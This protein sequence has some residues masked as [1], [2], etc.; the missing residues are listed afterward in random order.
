MIDRFK[1]YWLLGLVLTQLLVLI[2]LL[3]ILIS[4]NIRADNMDDTIGFFSMICVTIII[5]YGIL[6]LIS[7]NYF[8][9]VRS[10]K[11]KRVRVAFLVLISLITIS[12]TCVLI[13]YLLAN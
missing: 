7:Y 10:A 6:G 5:F 13:Y 9:K 2:G 8:K 1:K 12:S 4:A 3:Y 11:I